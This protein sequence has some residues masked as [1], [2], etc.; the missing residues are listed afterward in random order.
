MFPAGYS[1]PTCIYK[2]LFMLRALIFDVD[3]TLADTESA[4]R[5]AFNQAF[6]ELGRA[7][8]WDHATYTRLLDV[9]GGKERILHYWQQ[10]QPEVMAWPVD[11]VRTEVER[12]HASKTVAYEHAVRDGSV[13][14]RPGVQQLIV[15]AHAA[16]LKLAIAT[17]TT[18][19]NIAALLGA[20]LGADWAAYFAVIEDAS[21]APAKKPDPQVYVQALQRLGLPAADCMAFEDSANGLQAAQQAR[22]ATIITPNGFTADHDFTAALRILP[23]LSGVS[24][25]DL[26]TWHAQAGAATQ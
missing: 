6:A 12:I 24:L 16:G 4:H 19:A 15:S 20:T 1:T 17:T 18:P 11:T 25:V 23:D 3:G 7:W 13:P 21:T 10:V 5:L 14:L 2:P 22:L 9:S 8:V 26:H